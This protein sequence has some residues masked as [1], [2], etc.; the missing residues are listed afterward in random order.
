MTP[1]PASPW[2]TDKAGVL[3]VAQEWHAPDRV[4]VDDAAVAGLTLAGLDGFVPGRDTDVALANVF[5]EA[6]LDR[7]A[8]SVARNAIN[9]QFWD[10]RDGQLVRYAFEG[11]VG[12]L[13]M[14][15]AFEQAWAHPDSALSAARR[16]TPLTL[17]G[18]QEVFG[19]L[20]APEARV[21]ILNEIL[22]PPL[23][24]EACV[25]LVDRLAETNAVDTGMAHRL[26]ATFPRAFG[27]PVLKKA[28]LAVSEVWIQAQDAG[29]GTRCDLT[30]FADYQIPNVLRALGVLTYAPDLA[31]A[32]D[33]LQPLD[34]DGRDERAL[35]A[36][37]L[38]AVERIAEHAGAPV[39]AVDYYLWTRRKEVAT[40]F[41]LTFTTAY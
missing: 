31:Q 10:L 12:A 32:I 8:Q 24:S 26:A 25:A 28:Q 41:H 27:D 14:R 16:G 40:P 38:L 33:T 39:A 4:A 35:R 30:A 9:H 37:S 1:A 7:V 36:A 22:S 20:P 11:T 6:F 15:A 21:A 29:L 23:L 3:A 19:D 13:G 5:D 18:L 34:Y 2:P 17:A